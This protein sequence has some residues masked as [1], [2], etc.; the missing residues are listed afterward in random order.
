MKK[1]I[2]VTVPKDLYSIPLKHYQQFLKEFENI[3]EITD[4]TSSLKMLEIFCGL[5][6]KDG[7]NVK[8]SDVDLIVNK[9]NLVLNQKPSLIR[10][11]K[12]GNLEFGFIPELR[13][14]TFGEFID[15]ENNITDWNT[16]HKAMA[17]LYRPIKQKFKDK[18]TIEDY[19]GTHY[20]EIMRDMPSSVALSCI[21]FF[22]T[23][24][25]ELLK[26]TLN[27]SL[28]KKAKLEKK[29]S[30]QMKILE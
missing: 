10:K 16:I 4:H 28:K 23:L 30:E 19:D 26:V 13:D 5:P 29:V 8:M 6:I 2:E 7:M 12:L 9:L 3:E 18:Y 20:A 25:T 17:V 1:K 22:Y 14:L 24:E 27:Y 21:L 11:F 15:V